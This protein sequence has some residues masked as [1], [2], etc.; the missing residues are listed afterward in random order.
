MS[1]H[2][3]RPELI[4]H[5]I[6]LT[7]D[8][9][10][11]RTYVERCK[12]C[13]QIRLVTWATSDGRN[14]KYSDWNKGAAAGSFGTGG[15]IWIDEAPSSEAL[16]HFDRKTEELESIRD[17]ARRMV[18]GKN[19][20]Q[21]ARVLKT[22]PPPQDKILYDRDLALDYIRTLAAIHGIKPSDILSPDRYEGTGK[23]MLWFDE[24]P[25]GED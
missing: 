16:E 3:H 1:E 7:V 10:A 24:P 17:I 12:D 2:K 20:P 13:G 25:Q 23:S 9:S 14:R 21:W 5:T 11:I 6:T 4:P 15:Y 19:P 8:Q 22:A 18:Y